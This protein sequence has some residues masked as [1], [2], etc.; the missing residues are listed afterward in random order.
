MFREGFGAPTRKVEM[1]FLSPVHYGDHVDVDVIVEHVGRTSL[2]IRYEG[3]V[4]GKP[5]FEARN[6]IVIVDT[7]TFKPRP[8]P[9]WLRERLTGASG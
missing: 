4:S 9:N 3:S 8:I 1:E 2:R 5:V 6:T 7:Q